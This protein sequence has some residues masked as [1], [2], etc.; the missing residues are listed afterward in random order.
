MSRF[1]NATNHAV[2]SD[3]GKVTAEIATAY[4]ASELEKYRNI[5]DRLFGGIF[6]RVVAASERLSDGSTKVTACKERKP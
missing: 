2:L 5:Q 3:A 6:D 1:I 4:A